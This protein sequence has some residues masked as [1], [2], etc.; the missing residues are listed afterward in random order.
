MQEKQLV[1]NKCEVYNWTPENANKHLTPKA[2]AC[3]SQE[4]S[5]GRQNGCASKPCSDYPGAV[6]NSQIVPPM[7]DFTDVLRNNEEYVVYLEVCDDAGNCA[8]K[9]KAIKIQYQS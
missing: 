1:C 7:Y 9:E 8:K 6:D 4:C 3:E 5:C 2:G